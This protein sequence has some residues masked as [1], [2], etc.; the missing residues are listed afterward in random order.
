LLDDDFLEA[1]HNGIVL[2]CANGVTRC[3]FPCI[4]TYSADYPEKL[5]IAAIQDNGLC[6]CPRCL[7]PESELSRI[8]QKRDLAH[9]TK[10]GFLRRWSDWL[11]ITITKVRQLI[12][13]QGYGMVSAAVKACL[14]AESLVPTMVSPTETLS[15]DHMHGYSHEP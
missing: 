4:F 10:P 9:R 7:T 14:K 5:L 15:S 1:Y 6:P 8:G 13:E 2:K 12:Y 3:V 11:C